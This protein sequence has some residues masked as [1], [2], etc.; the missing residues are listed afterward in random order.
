MTSTRDISYQG[1]PDKRPEAFVGGPELFISFFFREKN[2]VKNSNKNLQ[3]RKS[4]IILLINHSTHLKER[5]DHLC[6]PIY[7]PNTLT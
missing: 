6:K 1:E 2:K 7:K 5:K 3:A 4:T